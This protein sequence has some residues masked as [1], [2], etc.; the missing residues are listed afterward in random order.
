M[1]DEIKSAER[2]SPEGEVVFT[3]IDDEKGRRNEALLKRRGGL[4]FT[5]DDSMYVYYAPTHWR[6]ATHEEL[7]KVREE[8]ASKEREAQRQIDALDA[9]IDKLEAAHA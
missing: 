4:W 6:P 8:L 2:L 7:G 9:Q 1:S 3:V 5:P